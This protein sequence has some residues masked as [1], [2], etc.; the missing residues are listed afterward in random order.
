MFEVMNDSTL[1]KSKIELPIVCFVDVLSD[2][3]RH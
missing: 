1:E 3:E 2:A